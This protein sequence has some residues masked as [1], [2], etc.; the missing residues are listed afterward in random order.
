MN[1]GN[2]ALIHSLIEFFAVAVYPWD[3]S[4]KIYVHKL[5]DMLSNQ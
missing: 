2:N 4:Y 3:I 1:W 5:G